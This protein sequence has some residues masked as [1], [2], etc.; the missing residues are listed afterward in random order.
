MSLRNV[1]IEGD[2]ILRKKQMANEKIFILAISLA[3]SAY[4]LLLVLQLR[5]VLHHLPFAPSAHSKMLA[6]R[7]C[8]QWRRLLQRYGTPFGITLL[9][10]VD[11]KVYDVPWH[12]VWDKYHHAIYAHYGVA[13]CSCVGYFYVANYDVFLVSAH[14]LVCFFCVFFPFS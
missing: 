10:L 8:P 3:I 5:S 9:F 13:L 1:V 14:G 12:Y 2:P 4:L 6:G 7:L 11:I